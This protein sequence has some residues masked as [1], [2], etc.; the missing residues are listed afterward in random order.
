[1]PSKVMI[2]DS[3][4]ANHLIYCVLFMLY[5]SAEVYCASIFKFGISSLRGQLSLKTFE[6]VGHD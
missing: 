5:V 6:G 1:M 3:Q 2:V 4:T